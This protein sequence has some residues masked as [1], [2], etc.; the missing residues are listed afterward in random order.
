VRYLYE[1]FRFSKIYSGT[2]DA[3][4]LADKN[5]NRK[6][7]LPVNAQQIFLQRIRGFTVF[8]CFCST[9]YCAIV[10]M[11]LVFYNFS[12]GLNGPKSLLS[13]HSFWHLWKILDL[14]IFSRHRSRY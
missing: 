6:I 14:D 7:A 13:G 10:F 11:P 4:F 8:Q 3:K 12:S 2:Q 1:D 9:K 5:Q